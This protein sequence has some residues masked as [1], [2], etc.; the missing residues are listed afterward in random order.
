MQTPV[1]QEV[2]SSSHRQ[3]LKSSAII[4]GSSV[5][6]I[7]IGIVKVKVLAVLL[8][9]AGI[10]LMGMFQNIMGVASVTAGCGVGT[11]GVRQLA[12]SEG[13]RDILD[14]VRHALWFGNLVLGLVGGSILWLL[15]FHISLWA[16][17]DTSYTTEV[18]LLGIGVWFTLLASSQTVLLQGL[19][20]IG[21]LARVNIAASVFG[22]IF[23]VAFA[24]WLGVDGIIWFVIIAPLTATLTGAWYAAKLPRPQ[25]KLNLAE[26]KAQLVPML[27][28]GV[29][30]MFTTLLT[31]GTQ[32]L[33]RTIIIR[34][35]GLDAAGHFQAS[36]AISMNYIGFILGAMATD[37]FPRLSVVISDPPAARKL[38][39]E[40]TEMG[41]LLATPAL[42]FMI[43]SAPWV[44]YL[45]YA[46][47]FDPAID[48]LRWQSVGN[49]L[50]VVSWPMRFILV[51]QA[52]GS[53]FIL[54]ETIADAAYLL[55]LFFGIQ[56]WGIDAAGYGFAFMYAIHFVTQILVANRVLGYQIPVK[57]FFI[58]LSFTTLGLGI[59]LVSQI[60]FHVSLAVGIPVTGIASIICIHRIEKHVHLLAWLRGRLKTKHSKKP[61]LPTPPVPP[62][63]T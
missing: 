3:I 52:R 30:F 48:L 22:A 46:S 40:Q 5:I 4:G 27:R 21:F 56:Y 13:N 20:R 2:P 26:T 45:F 36:W 31:L 57:L 63:S 55:A 15:R 54:S 32:F 25:K 11:S 9:A 16:F 43:T 50:R 61:A 59:L 49:F 18:G 7:A 23:G 6:A 37:Y 34:E 1:P 14:A 47:D 62:T 17:N 42:L 58:L 24:W 41:L 33:S 19:R 35:L 53:L 51:A 12:A 28:L 39:A 38:V 60:N 10:G 29:P 44:I 8:G